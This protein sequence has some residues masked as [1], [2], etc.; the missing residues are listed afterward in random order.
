MTILPLSATRYTLQWFPKE[1]YTMLITLFFHIL[2][3]VPMSALSVFVV[4]GRMCWMLPHLY[5]LCFLCLNWHIHLSALHTVHVSCR[6]HSFDGIHK[7]CLQLQ[8]AYSVCSM[9][10]GC[11]V[12]SS[13]SRAIFV[14]FLGPFSACQCP[15]S[16]QYSSVYT[17]HIIIVVLC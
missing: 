3:L 4:T 14:A 6:M 5:I 11:R 1:S 8:A 16:G 10:L 15:C 7:R 17:T 9:C 2:I 12:F 13:G